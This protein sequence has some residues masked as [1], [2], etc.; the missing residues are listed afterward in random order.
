MSVVDIHPHLPPLK[1][2][3]GG[4]VRIRDAVGAEL[5]RGAT[6]RVR[7]VVP[8]QSM[9]PAEPKL[10][11]RVLPVPAEDRS[12]TRVGASVARL[13]PSFGLLQR[14]HN[15]AREESRHRAALDVCPLHGT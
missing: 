2:V 1:A 9:H 11:L 7:R 10:R 5:V 3:A 4:D 6:R 8:R 14:G 15:D 12:S 13:Q